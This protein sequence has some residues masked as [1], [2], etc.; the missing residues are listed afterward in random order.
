MYKNNNKLTDVHMLSNYD[1]DKHARN[2]ECSFPD[3]SLLVKITLRANMRHL[4]NLETELIPQHNQVN[5]KTNIRRTFL[6][7]EDAL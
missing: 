7:G 2:Y 5:L 1:M 3:R 4:P 6:Q